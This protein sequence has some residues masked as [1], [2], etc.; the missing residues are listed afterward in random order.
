[1]LAAT[2][3]MTARVVPIPLPFGVLALVAGRR[4]PRL[5]RTGGR[6]KPPNDTG[7]SSDHARARLR[8]ASRSEGVSSSG[9]LR[10]T[11]RLIQKGEVQQ[12]TSAYAAD[13]SELAT[14]AS[15]L[16][17]IAEVAQSGGIAR[18][19]T[20][21]LV[22]ERLES[23]RLHEPETRTEVFTGMHGTAGAGAAATLTARL[24][25]TRMVV[26]TVEVWLDTWVNEGG[27]SAVVKGEIEVD[28]SEGEPQTVFD[29]QRTVHDVAAIVEAVNETADLVAAYDE[30]DLYTG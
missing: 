9:P 12:P 6:L 5:T 17:C 7:L 3:D 27:W 28:D 30:P 23:G 4:W 19:Q 21:I 13:V 1:M 24:A 20:D 11:A 10:G 8:G 25:D 18:R 22:K 26:W 2:S 15:V 29:V 14:V 16:R